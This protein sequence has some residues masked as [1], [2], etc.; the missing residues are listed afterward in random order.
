MMLS[1]RGTTKGVNQV[2]R[3]QVINKMSS[4][5]LFKV[6]QQNFSQQTVTG[7]QYGVG[8]LDEDIS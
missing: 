3:Q 5:V 8:K 7:D 4:N 6:K 1:Y 2:D